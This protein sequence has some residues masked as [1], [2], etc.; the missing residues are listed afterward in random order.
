MIGLHGGEDVLDGGAHLRLGA[1]GTGDVL[2]D[3]LGRGHY[4]GVDDLSAA[5]NGTWIADLPS[6]CARVPG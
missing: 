4:R 5:E 6:I 3:R 2:P 1:V